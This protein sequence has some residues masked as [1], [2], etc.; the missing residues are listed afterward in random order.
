[1]PSA[2]EI[3][4]LR[5]FKQEAQALLPRIGGE[6]SEDA[7]SAF[8]EANPPI[9]HEPFT[10]DFLTQNPLPNRYLLDVGCGCSARHIPLARKMDM[11]HYHGIDA[12]RMV[13][14]VAQRVYRPNEGKYDGMSYAIECASL[15]NIGRMYP[16]RFGACIIANVLMTLPRAR[17]Q[18]ALTSII[19]AMAK[20]GLGVLRTCYGKGEVENAFG[21]PVTL[22]T[23]AEI[24]EA[25]VAAGAQIDTV[26]VWEGMV[27]AFFQKC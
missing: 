13:V 7:L 16:R 19:H 21:L 3:F 10:E 20:D 1:M 4:A 11:E 12:V 9:Y 25:L 14:D 2:Q 22:Y 26:D 8:D 23:E 18:A 27:H 17:L 24:R 5:H 15:F 6:C